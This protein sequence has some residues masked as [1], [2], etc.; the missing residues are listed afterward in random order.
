MVVPYFSHNECSEKHQ[1]FDKQQTSMNDRKEGKQMQK[2]RSSWHSVVPLLPLH[3]TL[4][5]ACHQEQLTFQQQHPT[6]ALTMVVK[7]CPLLSSSLALLHCNDPCAGTGCASPLSVAVVSGSVAVTGRGKHIV[8]QPSMRALGWAWTLGSISTGFWIVAVRWIQ[9]L[10]RYWEN[11]S[12]GWSDEISCHSFV[13]C[14][15]MRTT[16]GVKH[17]EKPGGSRRWV[18]PILIPYNT[19]N[20]Y[21]Q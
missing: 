11:A 17:F 15:G 5:L 12:S 16:S 8:N 7:V 10:C 3:Q 6:P 1:R 4:N 9:S 2:W 19:L 13:M 20:W 14:I 18:I 21:C